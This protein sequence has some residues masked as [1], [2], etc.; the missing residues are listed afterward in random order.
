MADDA[1][2]TEPAT[3]RRRQ[4]AR[5]R[6]QVAKSQD[7]T[8]SILLLVGLLILDLL[9]GPLFQRLLSMTHA[10]LGGG[11]PARHFGGRCLGFRIRRILTDS[12]LRAG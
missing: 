11:G 10:L 1:E 8:A 5:T 2:R 4:E 9:G 3:P 12:G 6:G 7:L